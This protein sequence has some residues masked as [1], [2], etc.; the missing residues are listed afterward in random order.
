MIDVFKVGVNISMTTNATQV[1]SGMLAQMTGLHIAAGK[2]EKSLA[3]IGKL[4]V[5]AGMMF[6]GSEIFR[7]MPK[8]IAAGD[9]LVEQQVKLR[10]LGVSPA[11]ITSATNTAASMVTQVPGSELAHNLQIIRELRGVLKDTAE[12]QKGAPAV[13][14]LQQ[15]LAQ[16]NIPE[17]GTLPLLKALDI[18]GSFIKNGRLDVGALLSAVHEAQVALTLTG[19]ILTPATFYR[20]MRLA[21]PAASAM[22]TSEYLKDM[23]EVTMAL[24]PTGGRGLQMAAK[25]FLGGNLTKANVGQLIALGLLKPGDISKDH[26][27]YSIRTG[28]HVQGYDE[29]TQKGFMQW[30]HDFVEP[31]MAKHGFKGD[32]AVLQALGSLPVTEQRLFSFLHTN[33]AQIAKFAAQYNQAMGVDQGKVINDGSLNQNIKDFNAAWTSFTEELGKDMVPIA[34]SALRSLTAAMQGLFQLTVQF[35]DAAKAV[36]VLTY[37]FAGFLVLGG[38]MKIMSVALGP[39]VTGM[40]LLVGMG[41]GVATVGT[42]LGTV[43]AGFSKLLGPLSSVM[44]LIAIGAGSDAMI[45]HQQD[46]IN[47]KNPYGY[48]GK[49]HWNDKG[50]WLGSP[51]QDAP[52]NV[53][54]P[55]KQSMNNSNGPIHV[56]VTNQ[57]AAADIGRSITGG[58]ADATSRPQSGPTF[59]DYRFDT[60][61]PGF[62]LG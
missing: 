19:G 23:T 8:L 4:A 53:A 29:L 57:L 1:I 27:H 42:G 14:A 46:E 12:A 18:K 17:S 5:G 7:T 61:T 26:G 30:F 3:S 38:S 47:K 13:A 24:G 15:V 22:N 59:Q 39:F 49:Y 35:P 60:P 2:L 52:S 10:A 55:G 21:G 32:S 16:F 44:G 28:H 40:R 33:W 48:Y 41:T 20:S 37:S 43:A 6:A 45:K 9:R 31:A 58:M 51:N 56:Y 54:R 11:H 36:T 50:Y 34:I 62:A 25:T